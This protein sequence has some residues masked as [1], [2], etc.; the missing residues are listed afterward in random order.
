MGATAGKGCLDQIACLPA[1][2]HWS[3]SQQS[4]A[5]PTHWVRREH[6]ALLYF[7]AALPCQHSLRVRACAPHPLPPHTLMRTLY[8]CGCAR[9]LRV[10]PTESSAPLHTATTPTALPRMPGMRH[11]LHCSWAGHSPERCYRCHGPTRL[12]ATCVLLPAALST[13]SYVTCC[14]HPAQL[15]SSPCWTTVSGTGTLRRGVCR[16]F[17]TCEVH[18]GG[19]V[20][21]ALAV[22][23]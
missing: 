16:T 23:R 3:I 4:N 19:P 2:L 8:F 11:E 22:Y 9:S 15:T 1:Y 7:H 18:P 10:R 13:F 17:W 12:C 21:Q 5:L 14:G 6:L 20:S